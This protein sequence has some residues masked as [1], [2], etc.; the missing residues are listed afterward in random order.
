MDCLRPGCGANVKSAGIQSKSGIAVVGFLDRYGLVILAVFV[1]VAL[2]LGLDSFRLGLAAKYLCFAFPAVGIVLL[3]GYGGVLSLG[4]G[5]FFGLGSY[6]MAMFLKLESAANAESS[7][8]T[9]LAA[10]FGTAGLP[11]FMAWNSVEKLPWWWEPFHH[12]WFMIP[13]ILIIPAALAFLLGYANFRRRVSGVYFAIVTL[14]VS[15]IMAILIIGQQGLT[16]GINGITDFKTFLG[17][18][19]DN[20]RAK[21]VMYFITAVLLVCIV[22]AG[23]FI[24]RSRLG[25]VLVAI[26]DGGDRVRFTGYDSAMFQAFVFAVAAMFAAIGGAMFTIQIGLASPA[27]VGIIPSIEMVIYAAVGGRL[28]LIGAVYGAFLVNLAKTFFSENFVEYW[29]YFIGALFVIVVMF[30]PKGLAGILD[31]FR[32]QTKVER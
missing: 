13:A 1:L 30:L 16:G 24:L 5:V 20:D 7:S 19:L 28:S 22:A 3:W 21:L 15:A 23:Q 27:L 14:S 6:M 10:F 17:M 18:D 12:V 4:Q 32:R 2:P 8:G 9:Q 11:D 31:Y 26:R 29:I 25:R